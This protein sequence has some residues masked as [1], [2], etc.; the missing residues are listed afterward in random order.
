MSLNLYSYNFN[1]KFHNKNV[2]NHEEKPTEKKTNHIN[3]YI[4][5][6]NIQGK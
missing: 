6:Y 5:I 1:W 2:L 4:N 3:F